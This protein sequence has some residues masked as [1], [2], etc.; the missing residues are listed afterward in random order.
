[1]HFVD[2]LKLLLLY[3]HV[4][5]KSLAGLFFLKE[6][7]REK[8]DSQMQGDQYIIS[9]LDINATIR[10]YQVSI[11]EA[12]V[13]FYISV[14]RCLF[15]LFVRKARGHLIAD[16]DPLGIQNPESAKL[17]G[18]ANLPPAIVVRQHL[19]GV[20]EAD[21]DREFPL[22]S[23]TVIGGDKRSL[24]LRE[25]LTRLNKIYCGHLGL[26]YTYIHDLNMVR[27]MRFQLRKIM[28]LKM[29]KMIKLIFLTLNQQ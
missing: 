6:S 9:A 15:L 10:A 7:V 19:K 5:D 17:Q 16:T 25:I 26:E 28:H 23:L 8:S 20:T 29:N 13:C 24:P 27:M 14:Y 2:R 21:M 12:L 18:T 3:N 4:S 1:M 11:Y 22:A